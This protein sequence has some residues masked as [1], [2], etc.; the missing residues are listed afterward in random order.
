M[1]NRTAIANMISAAKETGRTNRDVLEM[2]S[3]QEIQDVFTTY[4]KA[5][6][7]KVTL[8]QVWIRDMH[9]IDRKIEAI[10]NVRWAA[11]LQRSG[12]DTP[13]FGLKEAKDFVEGSHSLAMTPA[14]FAWVY[15]YLQDNFGA[16]CIAR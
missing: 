11:S 5:H 2:L 4:V 8:Q 6:S 15:S 1:L 10:K 3:E 13:A 16:Y 7:P 14:Q 12:V 9:R